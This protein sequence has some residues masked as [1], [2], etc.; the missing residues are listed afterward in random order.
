[1]LAILVTG[2]YKELRT[3][4]HRVLIQA[5]TV[6]E[7]DTSDGRGDARN[8]PAKDTDGIPAIELPGE[9][10]SE[11]KVNNSR[12]RNDETF[13]VDRLVSYD[14]SSNRFWVSWAGYG[15]K[16]DTW[17]P[18]PNIMFNFI[19]RF[20]RRRKA[21]IPNAVASQFPSHTASN[22]IQSG[23]QNANLSVISTQ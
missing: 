9:E 7:D 1:M 23:R 12:D 6:Y 3:L 17:E 11:G 13:F 21:I 14:N 2:P 18:P 20:H 19:L 16:E 22:Q 5:N 4:P 15:P 10:N 8:E